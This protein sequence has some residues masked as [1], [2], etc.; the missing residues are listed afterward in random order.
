[1]RKVHF[2]WTGVAL[3]FIA[4][5][6]LA[7]ARGFGDLAD[8][9]EVLTVNN[10][11]VTAREFRMIMNSGPVAET[12]AYFQKKHGA[13]PGKNF[14]ESNFGGEIPIDYAR[15]KTVEALVRIKLNQLLMKQ[16]GVKPDLSYR[17]FIAG[18]QKENARRKAAVAKGEPIYGPVEYSESEYF[19]YVLTND[20]VALKDRLEQGEFKLTE[21][22]L[23]AR[24]KAAKPQFRLP[25][26]IKLD[27]IEIRFDPES[28][29][30]REAAK[31][32]IGEAQLQLTGGASFESV[33]KKYNKNG[34]MLVQL[35]DETTQRNDDVI[36]SGM[37]AIAEQLQQGQMSEVIETVGSY[38]I[39][40]CSERE[41]NRYK[42]LTEVQDSLKSA[43]VE[44]QLKKRLDEQV[45][46]AEVQLNESV[47]RRMFA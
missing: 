34:Q 15:G 23:R 28:S 41:T 10:E 7:S 46:S 45:K 29:A 2:I 30:G 1:M 24:Y 17:T 22:E 26:S 5:V 18:W 31:R 37:K 14:W 35:F 44:E 38:V 11:P 39:L 12:Y 13:A 21:E 16:N 6:L 3:V 42:P 19:R 36:Y 43:Y 27:K 25:D 47:Y 8:S 20:E 9:A 33:Q 40:R 32:I 4:A